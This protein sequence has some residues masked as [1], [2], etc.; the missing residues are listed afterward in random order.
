MNILDY[1]PSYIRISKQMFFLTKDEGVEIGDVFY[2]E[3]PKLFVLR[4]HRYDSESNSSANTSDEK[5]S[6][7]KKENSQDLD[8]NLNNYAN[9]ERNNSQASKKQK[10]KDFFPKPQAKGFLRNQIGGDSQLSLGQVNKPVNR[11]DR[12]AAGK[13]LSSES[14]QYGDNPYHRDDIQ[15]VFTH[16]LGRLPTFMLREDFVNQD[17]AQDESQ[18]S[19]NQSDLPQLDTQLSHLLNGFEFFELDENT[20]DGSNYEGNYEENSI[21]DE[22]SIQDIEEQF[23]SKFDEAYFEDFEEDFENINDFEDWL[24]IDSEVLFQRDGMALINCYA[25]P[26]YFWDIVLESFLLY[27]LEGYV[28]SV[29][30]LIERLKNITSG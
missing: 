27:E 20:S 8:G 15:H 3:G 18:N 16:E 29:K 22:S 26:F 11:F 28:P 24:V 17:L 13:H 9:N 1:L 2:Q 4:N 7:E 19:G 25:M 14:L 12:G 30:A 21:Q 6:D 23:F 10:E 5:T